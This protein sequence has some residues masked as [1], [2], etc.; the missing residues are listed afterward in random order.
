VLSDQYLRPFAAGDGEDKLKEFH[1]QC[2]IGG[3]P[4]P[5]FFWN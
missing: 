2:G 1:E 3:W 5:H 4:V